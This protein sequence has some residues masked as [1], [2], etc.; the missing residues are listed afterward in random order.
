MAFESARLATID[1]L[2]DI[3][4]IG[5]AVLAPL[6]DARGGPIFTAFEV[7]FSTPVERAV[8]ANNP[9]R[10]SEHSRILSK[11]G[12]P[13]VEWECDTEPPGGM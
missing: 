10:F 9:G 5:N 2:A 12:M 7:G 11:V 4:E 3:R 6:P 8:G 1:D 13:R